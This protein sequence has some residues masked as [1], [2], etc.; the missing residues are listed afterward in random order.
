MP[1]VKPDTKRDYARR[2]QR[3]LTHIQK[4]L[5]EPLRLDDL[6][7]I[8]AFSPF[9]FHRVFR[10]MVGET[11]QQHVKRLRLERAASQLRSSAIDVTT[12]AFDAGYQTLESFSRAFSRAFACGPSRF[13]ELASPSL[14]LE[15]PSAVHFGDGD[16]LRFA[17]IQLED[18]PMQVEIK[19]IA[20]MRAVYARH[21][22]P[23]D[24][25]GQTWERL[26]DW[27]GAEMLFGPETKLFGACH[28][29]PEVTAPENL[30]YDAC[31]SVAEDVKV[32]DGLGAMT[33]GGGRW[34]VTLHEGPYNKLG[35]TY[36]A[37]FGRWFPANSFEPAPPPCLEFYLNDPDS[38][39]PEDLLTEVCVR[40]RD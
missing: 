35:E 10:G 15:A 27:A 17:P 34:A 33:F 30:R 31:I 2:V 32:P 4:H 28:D 23:Y 9:H 24:A 25:V 3:V 19:T 37:L 8:A 16:G 22:G 18:R 29:D 26:T 36:A 11:L 14:R 38:T 21:T 7:A 20:P 39:E 12:I 1:K 40:I 13:R 6:A 5:D